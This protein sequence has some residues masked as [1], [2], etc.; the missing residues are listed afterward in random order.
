MRNLQSELKEGWRVARTEWNSGIRSLQ[1]EWNAALTHADRNKDSVEGAI[2]TLGNAVMEGA[3]IKP[4]EVPGAPSAPVEAAQPVSIPVSPARALKEAIPEKT[5]PEKTGPEKTGPEK[6]SPGKTSAPARTPAKAV[7]PLMSRAKVDVS[8]PLGR[9]QAMVRRT[10]QQLKAL[11]K[12]LTESSSLM[13]TAMV[14]DLTGTLTSLQEK[15]GELGKQ[16]LRIQ[17]ELDEQDDATDAAAVNRIEARLERIQ[18]LARG[19]ELGG[20]QHKASDTSQVDSS[21][22]RRELER[23]LAAHRKNL[24]TSELLEARLTLTL[25]RL[26]EIGAAATH[27]RRDLLRE[28]SPARSASRLLEQLTQ[29]VTSAASA[30]EEVEESVRSV[31]P[32]SSIKSGMSESPS[33]KSPAPT[34]ESVMERMKRARAAQQGQKN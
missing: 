27:S 16:A 2:K 10:E 7:S 25:A 34:R 12:A 33:V 18:T 30:L 3:L 11:E 26:L 19:A 22:E 9:V 31:L 4:I 1:T 8:T 24:Q 5:G 6:T 13:P 21:A 20:N 29:E 32:S 28:Q 15:A 14:Q 17:Q 23:S